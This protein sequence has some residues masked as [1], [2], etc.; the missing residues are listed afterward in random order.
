MKRCRARHGP[1]QICPSARRAHTVGEWSAGHAHT[2][3]PAKMSLGLLLQRRMCQGSVWERHKHQSWW[4]GLDGCRESSAVEQEMDMQVPKGRAQ[5]ACR[6]FLCRPCSSASALQADHGRAAA[7]FVFKPLHVTLVSYYWKILLFNTAACLQG[8]V[9]CLLWQH[10]QALVVHPQRCR[11]SAA[12]STAPAQLSHPQ[13]QRW[14]CGTWHL[15]ARPLCQ[16][17]CFKN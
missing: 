12:P 9:R 17:A 6:C 8:T 1:T 5:L 4:A 7:L 3:E 15:L 11:L 2:P 16:A 13:Q 14:L 10:L